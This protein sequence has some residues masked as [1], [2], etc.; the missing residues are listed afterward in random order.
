M[1]EIKIRAMEM[2]REQGNFREEEEDIKLLFGGKVM[3][4]DLLIGQYLKKSEIVL[5]FKVN[6][7][8]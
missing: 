8:Q 4:D 2:V 1:R 3:S 7:P 5:V 6:R